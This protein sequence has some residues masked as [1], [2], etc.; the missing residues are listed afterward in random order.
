MHGYHGFGVAAATRPQADLQVEATNLNTALANFRLAI[1]SW[2]SPMQST[3]LGM[4]D[5]AIA[6]ARSATPYLAGTV[7]NADLEAA[8]VKALEQARTHYSAAAVASA[9]A[10]GPQASGVWTSGGAPGFTPAA[11]IGGGGVSP[12]VWVGLGIGALAL[13]WRRRR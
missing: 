3:V 13:F 12:L 5:L 4:I 6:T 7:W 11:T 9:A 8:T 1:Q 2:K 10:G